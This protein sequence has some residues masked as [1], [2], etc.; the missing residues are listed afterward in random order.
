MIRTL[1]RIAGIVTV[2]ALG[3]G[4][5]AGGAHAEDVNISVIIPDSGPQATSNGQL[6]WAINTEAGSGAF[7]GGCNFL[8]AGVPGDTGSSRLWSADD[9]FYRA[10][11]GN[12]S[13]Q[14]PDSAG[15]WKRA[16]WATK[17]L[18]PTGRAV[19][20]APS[21]QGTGA[22]LVMDEGVGAVDLVEGTAELQWQGTFSVVF[23]GGLTYW[24]ATD[25][26]LSV[27]DGEGTLSATLSGYGSDM[28]DTSKWTELSPTRVVLATLSDVEL[29]ATGIS[30]LPDY[31]GIEIVPRGGGTAQVREGEHWG[32]F[33]QSFVDFQGETGQQAYWYSSGG[34]RDNVKPAAPL[35]ISYDANKPVPVVI[36][37]ETA[38]SAT[39]GSAVEAPSAGSSSDTRGPAAAVPQ[40]AVPFSGAPA[41]MAQDLANSVQAAV[42]LMG[43]WLG[44]G[45]IPAPL[46]R[47]LA[48]H[49]D[50]FLWALSALFVL[51]A[52]T[53]IGFRR[54][55]LVLPGTRKTP[56]A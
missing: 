37:E 26:Q 30:V 38:F 3:L 28:N 8:S 5:S 15:G 41:G 18:D 36:P 27:V 53:F 56:T 23:Y 29:G 45:L 31:R 44:T 42:Q 49:R 47:A 7:F 17:C 11:D 46:A 20:T 10:Q 34:V 54:G 21:E 51:A 33:P 13:I 16:S 4:L 32:G 50:A 9:G 43:T 6:R 25:P 22:Q 1:R 52:A 12:V 55:W 2:A 24:W 19:G 40:P 48:D 39:T 14:K 35:Y